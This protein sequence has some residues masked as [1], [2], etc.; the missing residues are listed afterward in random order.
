M[1]LVA[2]T[3]AATLVL[4][5]TAMAKETHHRHHHH[6][7]SEA[8]AAAPSEAAIPADSMTPHQAHMQNLRDSGHNPHDDLDANGVMKQN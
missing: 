1:K 8:N 4:A 5:G 3:A 7:V 6:L 2:L